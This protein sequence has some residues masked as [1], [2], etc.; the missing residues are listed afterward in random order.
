MNSQPGPL[1]SG[2]P[3]PNVAPTW[4]LTTFALELLDLGEVCLDL[5][6]VHCGQVPAFGVGS[7]EKVLRGGAVLLELLLV[8][9]GKSL[10]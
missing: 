6:S 3:T 2:A 5:R 7:G 8:V 9:H 4:A 10:S 1:R